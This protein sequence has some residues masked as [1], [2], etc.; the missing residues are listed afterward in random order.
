MKISNQLAK[1]A[2]GVP[3]I[4]G[5]ALLLTDSKTIQYRPKRDDRSHGFRKFLVLRQMN[6][7]GKKADHFAQ[8]FREHGN[9]S[10]DLFAEEGKKN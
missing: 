1:H 2:I 10:R 6:K 9:L 4:S 8:S 3:G 5:A 7:L